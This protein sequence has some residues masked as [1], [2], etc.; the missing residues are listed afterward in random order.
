MCGIGYQTSLF[1][2]LSVCLFV[3][4]LSFQTRSDH[5]IILIKIVISFYMLYIVAMLLTYRIETT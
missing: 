2:S 5:Q 1:K 4:K 3:L